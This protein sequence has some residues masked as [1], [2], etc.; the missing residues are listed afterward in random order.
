MMMSPLPFLFQDQGFIWV[1][2]RKSCEAR[3]PPTSP[4]LRMLGTDDGAVWGLAGM[5]REASPS[6]SGK[7]VGPPGMLS[8]CLALLSVLRIPP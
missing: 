6:G 7:V 5:E 1:L 4:V 8:L 2:K 3:S